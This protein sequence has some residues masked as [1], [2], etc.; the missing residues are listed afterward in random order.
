MA[1]GATT[2]LGRVRWWMW[3]LVALILAGTICALIALPAIAQRDREQG[4][5]DAVDRDGSTTVGELPDEQLLVSFHTN[6]ER[7]DEGWT[8]EQAS[9]AASNNWSAVESATQITKAEYIANVRALF[10]ASEAFCP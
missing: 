7:I 9:A 1:T 10:T 2:K 6:C 3:M 8:I 5:L 4:F